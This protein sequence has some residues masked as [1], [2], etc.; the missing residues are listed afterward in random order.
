[1]VDFAEICAPKVVTLNCRLL[2]EVKVRFRKWWKSAFETVIV[3]DLYMT[4]FMLYLGTQ[5]V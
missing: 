3:G 4:A 5:S 1:M 2:W